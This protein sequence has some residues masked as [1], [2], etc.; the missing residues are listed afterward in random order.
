VQGGFSQR[1]HEWEEEHPQFE[2]SDSAEEWTLDVPSGTRHL[3]NPG[4]IGQPRDCDWRAAFA[5]YDDAL[6]E[7]KF[8]RVPYD[9]AAAQAAIREAG[10]PERLA[11]RLRVGK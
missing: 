4:S 10:L 11:S 1:Q 9:V 7:V 8:C 5:V 2:H 3:I 6:E